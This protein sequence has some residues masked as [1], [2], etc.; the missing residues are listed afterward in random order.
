MKALTLSGLTAL[1]NR[2]NTDL[3]KSSNTSSASLI[4]IDSSPSQ[5]SSNLVSSDGIYQAIQHVPTS[6]YATSASRA[7]SAASA[8]SAAN[9]TS[10]SRATSAASADAASKISSNGTQGQVWT[11]TSATT[12]GWS[13]STGGSTVIIRTY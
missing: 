9:A 7:V 4:S 2:I 11:M 5:G 3:L 1:I 6:S 8:D 12:Q 13:S 10:A